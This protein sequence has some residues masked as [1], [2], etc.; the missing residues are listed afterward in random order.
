MW[1]IG[2]HLYSCPRPQS[3]WSGLGTGHWWV[4]THLEIHVYLFR[5]IFLSYFLD[6]FLSATFSFPSGALIACMLDLLCKSPN[7][8]SFSLISFSFFLFPSFFPPFV[9][10]FPPFYFS[11]VFP[12]SNLS[13]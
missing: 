3:V 5:E 9:P 12:S 13:I 11:A 6:D 1:H 8:L 4:S 10:P 7:F 2:L